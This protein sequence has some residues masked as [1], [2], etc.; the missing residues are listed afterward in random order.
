VLSTFS[1]SQTWDYQECHD[2]GDELAVVI[3]GSVQLLLDDGDGERAVPMASAE[4][5]LTPAGVWHRVAA[6]EPCTLMF[7]TP[8]PAR[9]RHGNVVDSV[10]PVLVAGADGRP[11]PGLT[12]APFLGGG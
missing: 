9:T 1:S 3:D 10:A 2:S 7:I 12:R 8:A 6:I 4:A 5:G 11:T